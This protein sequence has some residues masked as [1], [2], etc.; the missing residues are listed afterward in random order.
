MTVLLAAVSVHAATDYDQ[1]GNDTN[2][3]NR[4]NLML[5]QNNFPGYNLRVY[6]NSLYPKG[7]MTQDEVNSLTS[8]TVS[9]K[10]IYN[11]KG[12]ELLTALQRL[13]CQNNPITQLNL[14]GCTSLTTLDCSYCSSLTSLNVQGCSALKTLSVYQNRITG[15]GMT[16]LVNSL[17][18]RS[19]TDMGTLN[20]LWDTDEGN[21]ITA[22]QITVASSKYW[23]CRQR[24]NYSWIV[25]TGYLIGDVNG[26]G[27]VNIS[28]V[29]LL[30]NI[31]LNSDTP[32]AAADVNGDGQVNISDVIYLITLVL[33]N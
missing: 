30:S 27:Q 1:S 26:D 24:D 31:L 18:T 8:L 32:P 28:D 4:Y 9:S 20:V 12:V 19:A 25:L 17:P 13:D 29:V 10:N 7:Y 33:E 16:T 15:S 14:S 22:D 6:M 23:L 3:N 2:V 5:D 11:M 21:A